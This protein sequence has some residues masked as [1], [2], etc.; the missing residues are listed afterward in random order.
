SVAPSQ[1]V[2]R[3]VLLKNPAPTA[4]ATATSAS[5]SSAVSRGLVEPAADATCDA[6]M[7]SATTS[8]PR[9]DCS[10]A[11]LSQSL[12][13]SPSKQ[14]TTTST[15]CHTKLSATA[16]ARPNVAVP[17]VGVA[18]CLPLAE[19]PICAMAPASDSKL[20]TSPV[21]PPAIVPA[22]DDGSD[23]VAP[24]LTGL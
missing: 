4:T 23:K 24:A 22:A 18:A 16:P 19:R 6:S 21:S 5:T 10:T 15:V 17:L 7:I 14:P 13:R 9:S 3:A 11:L 1:T 8:M 12:I 20:A 2:A